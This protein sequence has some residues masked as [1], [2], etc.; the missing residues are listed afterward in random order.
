MVEEFLAELRDGRPVSGY[1]QQERI[2]NAARTLPV[3]TNVEVVWDETHET[4]GLLLNLLADLYKSAGEQIKN[5]TDE[6]DDSL[7]SLGDAFRR[8]SELDANLHSLISQP[9][10]RLRILGRS[11][12]GKQ[13]SGASIWPHCILAH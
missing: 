3:W 1:G 13:P 5:G 7:N 2:T 8:L 4:F 10:R 9:A 11:L 12:I 6:L